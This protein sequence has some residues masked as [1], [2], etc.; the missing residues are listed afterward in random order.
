MAV[1]IDP[2]TGEA[3]VNGMKS[4]L[5]LAFL[6]MVASFWAKALF[7]SVPYALTQRQG[8]QWCVVMAVPV[9]IDPGKGE[10]MVGQFHIR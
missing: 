5:S 8:R 6:L 2:E 4:E 10:V 9:L 7:M 3:I 1:I